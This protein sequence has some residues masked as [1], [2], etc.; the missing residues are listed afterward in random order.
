MCSGVK[1]EARGSSAHFTTPLLTRVA[2]EA[3]WKAWSDADANGSLWNVMFYRGFIRTSF[4]SLT[5][6][7]SEIYNMNM[8][9]V[10][11]RLHIYKGV[12]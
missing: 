6:E 11:G 3:S 7:V 4:V 5:L 1:K 12:T 8:I 2:G 10:R 9:R